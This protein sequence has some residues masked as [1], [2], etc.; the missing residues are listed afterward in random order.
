ML[1]LLPSTDAY[2]STKYCVIKEENNEKMLEKY[3]VYQSVLQVKL[4]YAANGT[5]KY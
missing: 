5:V 4:F 3:V 1:Q 2:L